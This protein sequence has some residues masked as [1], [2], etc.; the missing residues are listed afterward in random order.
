MNGDILRSLK[1]GYRAETSVVA[2]TCNNGHGS[3]DVVLATDKSCS[4]LLPDADP[5]CFLVFLAKT[6]RFLDELCE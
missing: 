1:V 2:M 6:A 4:M 3:V 5:S